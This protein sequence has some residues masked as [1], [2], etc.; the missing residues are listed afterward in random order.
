[1]NREDVEL[2][3]SRGVRPVDLPHSGSCRGLA[4]VGRH[5]HGLSIDQ[6]GVI[7]PLTCPCC[8]KPPQRTTCLHV[9]T[10]MERDIT[11]ELARRAE[12]AS[13]RA[14]EPGNEQ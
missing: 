1:M 5:S 2:A 3:L 9:I 13:Q 11:A 12:A 10:I 4:L 7:R 14:K 8:T 6:D